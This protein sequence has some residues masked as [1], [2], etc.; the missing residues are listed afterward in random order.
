[1]K[2]SALTLVVLLLS[3]CVTPGG[4]NSGYVASNAGQVVIGIG[5]AVGTRYMSYQ[6]YYRD[7]L[8]PDNTGDFAWVQDVPFRSKKPEYDND[9]ERGVVVVHSL[10][11][12]DYEIF[13]FAVS[14]TLGTGIRRHVSSADFSIPFSVVEG[15]TTYLGNYQANNV[16]G[17]SLIGIPLNAGA[18]FAVRDTS[19]RDIDIAAQK[20]SRTSIDDNQTLDSGQLP[21]PLFVSSFPIAVDD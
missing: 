18:V 11:P 3:A 21:A 10:P 7:T 4:L 20:G 19:D 13:N 12:G 15:Q 2:L 14:Q 9:S 8:N 1:M 5:A 17:R 16:R 6:L